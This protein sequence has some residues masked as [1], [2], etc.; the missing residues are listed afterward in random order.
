MGFRLLLL[1]SFY[2]APSRLMVVW[3]L[4]FSS[5]L[6]PLFSIAF[7]GVSRISCNKHSLPLPLHILRVAVAAHKRE[8]IDLFRHLSSSERP[9]FVRGQGVRTQEMKGH[10]SVTVGVDKMG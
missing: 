8:K 2:G 9:C 1:L 7:G 4:S 5:P 6:P 10:P 3:L